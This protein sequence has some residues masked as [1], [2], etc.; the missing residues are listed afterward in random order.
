[1][2]LAPKP[3]V[4]IQSKSTKVKT[5]YVLD[6]CASETSCVY[7]MV[8]CFTGCKYITSWDNHST[9][10]FFILTTPADVTKST[11]LTSKSSLTASTAKI[12]FTFIQKVTNTDQA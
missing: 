4:S 10:D 5:D 12:V 1:M 11:C 9:C 7:P 8:V 3:L 2:I 6:D